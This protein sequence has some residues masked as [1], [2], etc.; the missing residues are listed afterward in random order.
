[1]RL[2]N[3]QKVIGYIQFSFMS[4]APWPAEIKMYRIGEELGSGSFAHVCKCTR[5]SDN[6]SYAIKIFPKSN[7]TE[8]GSQDR[9]QREVTTTAYLNHENIVSLHDFFWDSHNFYM[10]T[11]LC[12]GGDLFTYIIEHHC[13][14]EPTASIFFR[15]V[16]G[17]I[18]YCHSFSV[19]HRDLKPENILI[20]KFPHIKVADFGICGFISP[21]KLM[22]TFYGSPCYCSPECL[23]HI[24]YDGK[25]SDIWSLGVLLFAMV[26]GELPWNTQNATLMSQQIVRGMYTIPYPISRECRDLISSM[27]KVDPRD[28]LTIEQVLNHPWLKTSWPSVGQRI[29]ELVALALP[30]PAPFGAIAEESEKSSTARENGICSPFET[31]QGTAAGMPKLVPVHCQPVKRSSSLGARTRLKGTKLQ[32]VQ[33]RQIATKT[34]RNL[35]GAGLLPP[36][37]RLVPRSSDEAQ[38]GRDDD[39]S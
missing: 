24:H 4:C 36:L 7:L 10:V 18:A 20:C 11:D 33:K 6:S 31:V 12:A 22:D 5:I 2:N 25:K 29:T 15:Q 9:F 21:H 1:M 28:R 3:F 14:D 30:D 34:V 8:P 19:A 23:C 35:S 26:T 37:P 27:M 16:A 32:V 39:P 17:A 13:I 38:T